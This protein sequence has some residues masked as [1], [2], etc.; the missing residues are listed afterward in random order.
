MT[1]H[2]TVCLFKSHYNF[3]GNGVCKNLHIIKLFNFFYSFYSTG[4]L[5]VY[6]DNIFLFVFTNEVSDGKN[7][8]AKNHRK[9]S[10]KKFVTI[11]VYISRFSGSVL[12]NFLFIHLYFSNI[13][14]NCSL[15]L[16]H[17]QIN[18]SN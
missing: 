4:I 13:Q 8:V 17:K 9:I 10:M 6:T 14:W 11:S 15:F 7:L 5:L 18:Y 16:L 2:C 12:T 3:I 1:R